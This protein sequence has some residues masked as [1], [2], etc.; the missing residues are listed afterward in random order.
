[1]ALL[2]GLVFGLGLIVSGMTNPS[3]VIGFLD[4][5]GTWD[6]SLAFVMVGAIFVGFFSF[7]YAAVLPNSLLGNAMHLPKTAHID[8]PLILGAAI[9]GIGWGLVGYCPGPALASIFSGNVNALI[10]TLAMMVGMGAYEIYKKLPNT[11]D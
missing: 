5:F 9:F 4:V 11:S 1:M 3:K 2:A 8:R 6:P 7:R 10:F